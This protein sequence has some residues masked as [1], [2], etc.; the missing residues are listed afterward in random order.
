MAYAQED[1]TTVEDEFDFSDFE[2]ATEPAKSFCTNKVLGQLPTTLVGLQYTFQAPHDFTAGN[3]VGEDA[4]NIAEENNI[5]ATHGWSFI[6]NLP[7]I[8]R[9]NILINANL[10]YSEQHYNFEENNSAHPFT[11]SVSGVGLRSLNTLFTVFK[12]LNSKNFIL[13]QVGFSINGNY[14]FGD[15][16]PLNTTRVPIAALYGWKASDKLMYAF[17]LSRTYLGGALNYVPI[18]YYYRTFNDNW[19]MEALLPA[20]ALVRYRFSTQEVLS[21]GFNVNGNTYRIDNF[22][23]NAVGIPNGPAKNA[24]LAAEDV[25]L[26]RS[27]IL[28]GLTYQRALSGFFWISLETGYRINYSYELDEGGDF[29]RPFGNDKAYFIE[30]TLGNPIYFQIGISYVSP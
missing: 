8:S 24:L 3:L 10:T 15:F 22:S 7:I 14:A 28:L 12:P 26:R 29:A 13:G 19:G 5:N 2:L 16:Q 20:R 23:N 18:A 6:T 21:F 27:E 1:S 17:G 25:E 4:Q 30:N 9:N 11:K